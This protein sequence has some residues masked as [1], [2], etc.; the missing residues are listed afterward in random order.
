MS[1]YQ[2]YMMKFAEYEKSLKPGNQMPQKT[3]QNNQ[4]KQSSQGRRKRNN[5][6]RYRKIKN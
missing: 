4:T 3:P 1:K 5:S 6:R 2:Y